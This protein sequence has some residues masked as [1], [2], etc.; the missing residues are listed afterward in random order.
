LSVLTLKYKVIRV[1]WKKEIIPYETYM[2]FIHSTFKDDLLQDLKTYPP[3]YSPRGTGKALKDSWEADMV[4][5]SRLDK[6]TEF[7]NEKGVSYRGHSWNLMGLLHEGTLPGYTARNNNPTG[8]MTFFYNNKWVRTRKV[9]GIDPQLIGGHDRMFAN[10][11]MRK[12]L[13]VSVK[14]N[15]DKL[16][17]EIRLWQPPQ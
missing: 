14:T 5:H 1:D 15:V 4:N 2:E 11:S 7:H 8:L 16:E 3:S 6:I 12:S 13:N 10:Y 17:G 9:K